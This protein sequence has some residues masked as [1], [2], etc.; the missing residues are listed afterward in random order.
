MPA[1]SGLWNNVYGATHTLQQKLT[2]QE[3]RVNRALNSGRGGRRLRQVLLALTGN[4]PGQSKVLTGTQI[5]HEES[6]DFG[7]GGKRTVET[8]TYQSGVTTA[9]DVT[10]VDS[11]LEKKNRPIPYPR[12]KA[13][14]NNGRFGRGNI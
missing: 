14:T 7:F 1:W 11:K 4:A 5:K 12:D 10:N 6:G 8:V 2:G 13:I 9:A 3:R